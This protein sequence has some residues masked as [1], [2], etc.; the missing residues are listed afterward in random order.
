MRYTQHSFISI[1]T[2]VSKF[3]N[4]DEMTDI[5]VK[6]DTIDGNRSS[7]NMAHSNQ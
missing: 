6:F 7:N 4:V 5:M 2:P 1:H 3:Q